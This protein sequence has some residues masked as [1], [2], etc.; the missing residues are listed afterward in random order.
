MEG[1]VSVGKEQCDGCG[2]TLKDAIIHGDHWRCG[3]V[4]P[5]QALLD[6]RAGPEWKDARN[7]AINEAPYGWEETI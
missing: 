1:R 2:Y 6:K 7:A 4:P 5:W 3:T